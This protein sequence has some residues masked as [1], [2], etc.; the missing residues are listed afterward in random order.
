LKRAA[1]LLFAALGPPGCIFGGGTVTR[2]YGG[3]EV[4]GRFV[5]P[6]AYAHYA[7][8]F[9]REQS[10]DDAGARAG[11]RAVLDE[12]PS[13]PD[14][15]VRLAAVQCRLAE[16]EAAARSFARAEHIDSQ[17]EPLWRERARCALAAGDAGHALELAE[18][19]VAL[20][21]DDEAASL[22]AADAAVAL[23][24]RDEA[25]RWLTGL[26]TRS[27]S[28]AG[29]RALSALD[30]PEAAPA[31][32]APAPASELDRALIR[33]PE[34]AKALARRAGMG[35]GALSARAAALGLVAFAGRESERVLAADPDDADAWIAALV[36]A[37]LERDDRRWQR[38]LARLGDEPLT[39]TP[40]AVRLLGELIARRA[41][42]DAARAWREAWHLP[43][44]ADELERTLEERAVTTP[45]PQ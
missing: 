39:P 33:A 44:P 29:K 10:G 16:R 14:A 20:D 3:H 32:A 27:R 35:P 45:E 19:A 40:L 36:V 43:P 30:A 24:R 18:R 17:F 31:T 21:P 38:A 15:W 42:A 34:S 12:D 6:E 23:G 41:G 26:V 7:D 5:S 28:A 25:R 1:A 11:Y 2:V 13:S 4:E 9:L 22:V 8:A 37:D